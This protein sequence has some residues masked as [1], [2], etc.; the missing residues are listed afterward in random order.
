MPEAVFF[1]AVNDSCTH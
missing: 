1:P